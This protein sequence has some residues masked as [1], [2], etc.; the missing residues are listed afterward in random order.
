MNKNVKAIFDAI[1]ADFASGCED[2]RRSQARALFLLLNYCP[3]DEGTAFVENSQ[4]RLPDRLL[5]DGLSQND[6]LVR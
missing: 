5:E 3:R 1:K 6:R 2:E 4:Q